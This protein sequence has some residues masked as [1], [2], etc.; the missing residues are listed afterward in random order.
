M[1]TNEKLL[2]LAAGTGIGAVL[3]VLFAPS[4]GAEIRDNLSTKAQRGV[5]LITSK[6]EEGKR[7][8]D[9]KGVSTGS[10]KNFVDRSKEKLSDTF[11]GVKDRFNESVDAGT[12][13]Y[14]AQ[15]SRDRGV[16]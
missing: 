14:H 16:M 12:E 11:E 5:D 10:V 4:S 2:Y 7:F 1:T 8:L 15:R 3:G 6:V 9:E 13:E